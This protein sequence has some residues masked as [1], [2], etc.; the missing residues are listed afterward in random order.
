MANDCDRLIRRWFEE[1]WNNSRAET[2]DEMIAP[3]CVAHGLH[4]PEGD[5][6]GPEGFKQFYAAFKSAFPDIRITVDEVIVDGDR[7]AARF[8]CRAT[9]RG[10]GLGIAATGQ[11]VTF[12]GMAFTRWRNGQI[13][14]AWN[15]VDMMGMLKQVGAV[16]P[17]AAL[18]G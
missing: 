15:N 13:V 11:P 7:C 16:Q 8:S 9:H 18:G 3:D 1:V 4:G 2:I 6:H 17:P 5:L 12:T 10:D 14:D